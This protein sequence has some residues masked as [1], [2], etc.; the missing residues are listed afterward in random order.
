MPVCYLLFKR[1]S[2]LFLAPL[3]APLATLA[4]HSLLLLIEA[5]QTSNYRLLI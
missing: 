5:K 4:T 2:Q 1:K 3:V